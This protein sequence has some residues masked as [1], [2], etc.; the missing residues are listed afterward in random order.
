MFQAAFFLT[1]VALA[2]SQFFP[3]PGH[4]ILCR[5]YIGEHT[6]PCT[7]M[8]VSFMEV[9]QDTKLLSYRSVSVSPYSRDYIEAY[10]VI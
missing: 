1:V 9:M 5:N 3:I 10:S 6:L 7:D 4:T 2:K 8:L